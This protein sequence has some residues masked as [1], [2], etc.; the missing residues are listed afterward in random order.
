[1][2][3]RTGAQLLVECLLAQDVDMGFGV[4]GE[5]YLAVLDALYDVSNSFR[6][7]NCRN[8]GGGAFMAEAYGKLTGNPGILFVTRGPG[9]TNA[10]IGIHTAMQDS[11]PMV[12]FVGQIETSMRGREAFQELDYKAVF[13]TMAKW[14]VEID[15]ADRVPELISR[16]FSMAIS[17]RPGPVVVALPE[18]MLVQETQAVPRGKVQP[19]RPLIVESQAQAIMSRLAA[20]QRPVVVVGGAAWNDAGRAA[21]QKFV[22]DNDLPVIVTF[23]S[24]DLIDNRSPNYIGDAGFGLAPEIRTFLSESDL[25]I[26]INVRFGET[27]TDGYRLFDPA[28]FDKQLIHIHI[29]EAELNKVFQADLAVMSCPNAALSALAAQPPVQ[30][31]PWGARTIVARTA[32]EKALIPAEQPGTVDMGVIMAHLRETIPADTIVTNGAGNFAIWP[33]RYLYYG[34]NEAGQVARLIGP[35]AGSMGAGVPAA[36]TAKLVDPSRFVLCFAGDGD[37]Q[38]N[39]ME[40][41]TAMQ[42][43]AAPVILLLNNG[44]Y[45]TIRMHQEREYPGRVSATDLV[46]PDFVALASAFGFYSERV[47]RTEDFQAAFKRATQAPRGAL[48]ELM[49]D[50][51]GISPRATISGLRAAAQ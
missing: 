17:G 43:G 6:F 41:A 30:N 11:T 49:I 38:M 48:L 19:V 1:M 46:N 40:L 37:F 13:G 29:S 23:R 39:G 47:E 36:V 44:T 7:I 33:G 5:S 9:A 27:L 21:L 51:E 50:P 18:D 2:T 31:S 26:A 4:P 35:Q 25:I 28:H 45:G 10:S 22:A 8:E 34:P 15:D 42:Y 20:A 32:W 14:V 24:Q 3:K 12:V 16:A